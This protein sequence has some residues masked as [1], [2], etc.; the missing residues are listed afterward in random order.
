MPT[1]PFPIALNSSTL[2]PWNLGIAEQ[3]D[4]ASQSGY[5]GFE[6]WIRDLLAYKRAGGKL[7]DLKTR[8]QDGGLEVVGAIGFI[9]WA[10]PDE[11]GRAQAIEQAKI[12]MAMVAEIGGSCMAAPP[13]GDLG[14]STLAQIAE[15]FSRFLEATAEC[16]ITP[17]LELWGFA[18]R[19]FNLSELL[20]VAAGSNSQVRLLLDVYHLYKGGGPIEPLGQLSGDAVGLFHVNDYPAEPHRSEISDA[21]RVFPGDG[22]APLNWIYG[23]LHKIGYRGYLSLELFRE[24]YASDDP[25]EVAKTGLS[26]TKASVEAAFS[27]E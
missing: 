17:Y 9:N 14:V 10:V 15:R 18:Q 4:I 23:T 22:V 3:I 16:G 19:I 21:D 24:R 2:L 1:L 27:G 7:S 8:L 13:C 25:L 11:C 6:P 20:Y 26:K 5:G 12:E